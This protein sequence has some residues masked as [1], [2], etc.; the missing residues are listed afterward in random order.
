MPN[1]SAKRINRVE[2]KPMKP[3]LLTNLQMLRYFSVAKIINANNGQS[4]TKNKELLCK[5]E[6]GSKNV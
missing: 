2:I 1:V 6:S 5:D 4:N 3:I